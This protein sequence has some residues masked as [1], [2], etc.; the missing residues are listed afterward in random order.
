MTMIFFKESIIHFLTGRTITVD[1]EFMPGDRISR[2]FFQRLFIVFQ[3]AMF[4]GQDFFT[5]QAYQ[6][7][8]VS[9]PVIFEKRFVFT[10]DG[11]FCNESF[12]Y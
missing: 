11:K 8:P 10:H 4:N 6:I 1:I 3:W 12:I 2:F 7:M 9:H 5:A